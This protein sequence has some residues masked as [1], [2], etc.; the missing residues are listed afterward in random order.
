MSKLTTITVQEYELGTFVSAAIKLHLEGF[1]FVQGRKIGSA[2]FATFSGESTVTEEADT[3]PKIEEKLDKVVL[4]GSSDIGEV[5]TEVF[6][7]TFAEALTDKDTLDDY[8]A[9]FGHILNKRKSLANMIIEL[10]EL[11][12]V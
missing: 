4:D 2:Y 11:L 8:A 10:K 5:T 12:A 7:L 3:A 9:K 6:D 1:S